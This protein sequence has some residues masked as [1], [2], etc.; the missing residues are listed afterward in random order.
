MYI[1]NLNAFG[2][3]KCLSTHQMNAFVLYT[4]V[5]YTDLCLCT[6]YTDTHTSPAICSNTIDINGMTPPF[7]LNL[8]EVLLFIA[9]GCVV[10]IDLCPLLTDRD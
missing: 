3:R 7:A 4:H 2:S 8:S 6:Y 1:I 9:I 5:D 10:T